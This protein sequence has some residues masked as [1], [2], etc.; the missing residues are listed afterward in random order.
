MVIYRENKTKNLSISDTNDVTSQ[1]EMVP[2]PSYT[3]PNKDV[4]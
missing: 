1:R 4:P 2:L 3:I